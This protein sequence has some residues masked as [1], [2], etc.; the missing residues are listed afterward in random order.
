MKLTRTVGRSVL[1][2]KQQSPHAFFALGLLG[3]V[4]STVLACRATLKL[5]ETLDTIEADVKATEEMTDPKDKVYVYVRAGVQLSKL[6]APAVVVGAGSVALLTGSHVQ[7]TRRNTALMAAYATL[8]KA[9][10]EYRA[11]VM[12]EFGEDREKHLHLG[13]QAGTKKGE[14]PLV[15]ANGRSPYARFF[16]EVSREWKKDAELNRMYIECQQNWANQLLRMRG[17][18]FLNE[19]Y[20]S[21]DIERTPEGA[22]VGWIYPS[23][24]GDNYISFGIHEVR[25][26]DFLDGTEPRILLDFNVDGVIYNLI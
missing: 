23:D 7:L 1:K 20:D 24:N 16:D 22:V 18:V 25:N 4:T 9:Y 13:T 19:V 26:A 2:A 3:S 5:R 14:T 8:Q 12:E 15:L 6:Y 17:H 11:R 21:L 10:E